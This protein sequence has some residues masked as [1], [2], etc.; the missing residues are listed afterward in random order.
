ML[1]YMARV[2]YTL[3]IDEKER[4]ALENLSKIKGRPV[5]KLLNEAIKSYL[6][7][8]S[9]SESTLENTLAR[10]KAYRK[11]DPDFNRA[12]MAF[13]KAEAS[14]EDPIEGKVVEQPQLEGAEPIQTMI[15][16][17]LGA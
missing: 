14:L 5:N 1:C 8:K 16:E 7:Q 10:L 6:H 9:R 17:I 2:A 13:I 12:T 3:R 11:E 4:A 15:R